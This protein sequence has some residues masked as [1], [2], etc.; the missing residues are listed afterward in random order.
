MS[1]AM[2]PR[3]IRISLERRLYDILDPL[4][5]PFSAP[6]R[7]FTAKKRELWARATTRLG[8]VETLEKG[9]TEALGLRNGVFIVQL[10]MLPD[11]DTAV[12]EHMCNDIEHGFRLASFDCLHCGEPYTEE[13]GLDQDDA[14]YQF[15]VTV[16]F[17]TW[18]GE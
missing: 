3:E 1:T 14:W 8:T 4:D 11:R 13:V 5:V 7:K 6:N 10:F 16:P 17:W 12:C 2:T 18:V 15:N 9:G